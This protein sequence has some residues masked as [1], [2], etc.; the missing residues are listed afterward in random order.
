M[1]FLSSSLNLSWFNH[2]FFCHVML[3]ILVLHGTYITVFAW[4]Y[5]YHLLFSYPQVSPKPWFLAHSLCIAICY[6]LFLYSTYLSAVSSPSCSTDLSTFICCPSF[7]VATHYLSLLSSLPT[8][9]I[10]QPHLSLFLFL[11]L[12]YCLLPLQSSVSVTSLSS[13][14]PKFYTSLREVHS[15]MWWEKLAPTS[16]CALST[17]RV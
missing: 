7:S 16:L 15:V 6:L 5:V 13:A 4:P 1:C 17:V 3:Y 10:C 9:W 8:L 2:L 11:F 14:L 12:F